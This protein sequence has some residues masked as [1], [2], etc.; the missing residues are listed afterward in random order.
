M[1]RVTWDYRDYDRE[2]FH[3]ELATFVPERIYDIH[4]HLYR[5]SDWLGDP[6]PKVEK[7]PAEITLEVYREQ[8]Q[9]ILPDREIHGL[10]FPFPAASGEN[11]PTE[12]PN[13][14]VGQEIR[15][16]PLAR[17]QFLVKPGDNPEWVRQEVKR[18]GLRGLKPFASYSGI[19]DYGQAEIPSY[20]P[21]PIVKVAHEEDWTITL[22]MM[23]TLSASDPSNQRWI[24]HY[25]RTYPRIRLILDHAAR[26]FNPYLTLKGL[27]NLK[28][29][30]NLYCDT[31][32]CCSPLAIMACLRYLGWDHVLYASDFF[33]SHQRGTNLGV[34]Q[35]LHWL[36][37]M[38]G[39]WQ[40]D[41][42]V[43]NIQPTLVGLEN[44]RAARAA[45]QMMNLGDRE[46]EGYFWDNAAGL[47]DL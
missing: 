42:E 46:I 34:N 14:W 33:C 11:F 28:G 2:F 35:A 27:E 47:L 5:V 15:K 18:L 20:L 26:G 7:G 44:L 9:W 25:C 40:E 30:D 6:P 10:H 19:P 24:R 8:M 13:A 23:R 17:G 12:E 29:L 43:E 38:E 41:K 22:H 36:V 1:N 4:A 21:E 31:S 3:R 16:D 45:F 37:E 39:C 32:V